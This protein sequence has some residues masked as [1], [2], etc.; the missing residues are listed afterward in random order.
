[1]STLHEPKVDNSLTSKLPQKRC[2]LPMMTACCLVLLTRAPCSAG[3]QRQKAIASIAVARAAL[4]I[5]DE[6]PI[7]PD[8]QRT[9]SQTS[10]FN[11]LQDR[12]GRWSRSETFA[13]EVERR[14]TSEKSVSLEP[15]VLPQARVPAK[16]SSTEDKPAHRDKLP[17]QLLI[18]GWQHGCSACVRLEHDVRTILTPLGWRIGDDPS[19]Q[20]RF[21]HVPVTEPV[22]QIRL[23]QNGI[24]VHT[25]KSYVDPATLSQALRKAWDQA[26]ANT[27]Q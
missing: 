8:R 27:T 4:E 3:T 19:D 23:Y 10:L 22:P 15:L 25:W 7:L 26:V 2:S 9:R 6:Q 11:H 13:D 1:M 17:A 20:I 18:A 24:V 21:V 14:H 16:R 12:N 5:A